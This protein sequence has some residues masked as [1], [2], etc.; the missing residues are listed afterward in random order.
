M[1]E[2]PI[3]TSLSNKLFLCAAALAVGILGDPTAHAQPGGVPLWTNRYHGPGNRRDI[4]VGVAVD[5]SGDVVVTGN[6]YGTNG[7]SDYATIKYSNAGLPL[8]TNRYDGPGKADDYATAVAVDGSGNVFVA[9]QS[10]GTN[11][12]SDY[13]TVAYSGAGVPLWTNRYNGPGNLYDAA[14]AVAVDSNG[15]VYVTGSSVRS[16]SVDYA[17]IK[18]SGAGVPLWTNRYSSG[19]ARALSVD[20]GGNVLVTGDSPGLGGVYDYVTIKYSGGGVPLWTNRYDGPGKADDYAGAIAVDSNGNVFVTGSSP[21]GGSGNDYATIA[22][23][24]VGL[25]LWTNRYDGPGKA[26]DYATAVAVDGSG[27]VFVAGQSYGHNGNSDYATVAYSG[28]GVPLWTNRY[29][30][31]ADWNDVALAI[32]L[33]SSGTVFVTG[34][35]YYALGSNYNDYCVTIAYSGTSVPLW[36]N[37][38]GFGQN[39]EARAL[40]VDGSGNVFATGTS[41]GDYVTIKYSSAGP[42]LTIART[43][44][45]TLAVS[46]PSPAAAFT[47]QQNTNVATTNWTAVGPTPADDGTN[48]TVVVDPAGGNRFYRLFRP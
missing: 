27:N 36:T 30:G 13:A 32:A 37:S 11:G 7:F 28:A 48:K 29:T 3:K 45:N 38:Y 16:G 25:P 35:S 9:G 5:N 44:T 18:Y 15:N 12:N 26:D 47:L 43:T 41:G 6:S 19:R 21:G 33:D 20:G 39:G 42:L 34:F 22:Y 14:S 4:A 8:W 31:P 23:S 46:W 1:N 24:S 40:A 17:T 10:C 2:A